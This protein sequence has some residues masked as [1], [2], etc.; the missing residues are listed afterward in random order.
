M[1]AQKKWNVDFNWGPAKDV[2]SEAGQKAVP[3]SQFVANGVFTLQ[4][5]DCADITASYSNNA[6]AQTTQAFVNGL[7]LEAGAKVPIV[8]DLAGQA[9]YS[10][11]YAPASAQIARHAIAFN[12]LYGN[13]DKGGQK[14][15]QRCHPNAKQ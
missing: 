15:Y 4:E 8:K 11:T 9:Q 12:L 13:S 10:L 6:A 3:T 7:K 14:L 5:I 2:Q 1:F